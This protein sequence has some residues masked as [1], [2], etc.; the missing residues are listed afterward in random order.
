MKDSTEYVLGSFSA[1]H[2]HG[3]TLPSPKTLHFLAVALTVARLDADHSFVRA[4]VHTI[5]PHTWKIPNHHLA[6]TYLKAK[7]PI[8]Y[9][10]H[11]MRAACGYCFSPVQLTNAITGLK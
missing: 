8:C 5:E 2:S 7:S 11:L 6:R 9:H 1:W 4:L 3:D 10:K